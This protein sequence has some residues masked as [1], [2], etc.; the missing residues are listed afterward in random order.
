MI[1]FVLIIYSTIFTK[2]K[3]RLYSLVVFEQS[4]YFRTNHT[5][6]NFMRNYLA[7]S[8]TNTTFSHLRIFF[9]NPKSLWLLEVTGVTET[10]QK[11]T[12]SRLQSSPQG[13]N[14]RA[15]LVLDGLLK[16]HTAN[17]LASYPRLNQCGCGPV[18][19]P[20]CQRRGCCGS[21]ETGCWLSLSSS[22]YF[23]PPR[24]RDRV[25]R[26]SSPLLRCLIFAAN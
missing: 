24:P 21:G 26:S 18:G 7:A 16:H 10:G 15:R 6:V 4:L 25:N 9:P 2:I 11:L 22:D 12:G 17:T 19:W 3:M 13:Q 5:L 8:R 14:A 23:W 20:G 1:F